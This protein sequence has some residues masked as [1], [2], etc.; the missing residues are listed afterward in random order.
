VIITMGDIHVTQTHVVLPHGRYPLK[1]TMWHVNDHVYPSQATPDWA[2]IAALV[3]FVFVCVFSLFFLL[4]KETRLH[5]HV[6]VVVTGPGG[7]HHVTRFPAAPH[8]AAWVHQQVN[9]ARAL[10]TSA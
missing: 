1:D 6:E 9:H 10:A 8:T 5:G 3:G 2:V 4:A 7:L